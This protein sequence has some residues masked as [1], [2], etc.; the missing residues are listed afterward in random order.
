MSFVQLLSST[1]LNCV[2]LFFGLRQF[3]GKMVNKCYI[4]QPPNQIV[5]VDC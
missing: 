2:S 3:I 5:N 1:D 4:M